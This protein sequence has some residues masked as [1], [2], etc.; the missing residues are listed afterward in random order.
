MSVE[1]MPDIFWIGVNDRTTDLFEGVWPIKEGVSY[2]SYL[3][4]DEKTVLVDLVKGNQLEEFL[5]K[6]E[7][8]IDP[9]ELDYVIINHMEPDHSGILKAIRRCAPNVQIVGTKRMIPMVEAFYGITKDIVEV[10]DGSTLNLGKRTLEFFRTPFV[11]WPETMMTFERSN[12]I[13]FSCDGFG[14]FGALRGAIFDDEVPDLEY[15][16]DEALRYYANIVAKFSQSVLGAI[17]KLSDL[18]IKVIAPSHGVIWRDHPEDIIQLYQKWASYAKGPREKAVTLVYGSMYGN[19]ESVMNFV[20]RGISRE[21]VPVEICDAARIHS[22]YILAYLWKN[23]G[24]LIGA[25]TYEVELFPPVAHVLDMARRKSIFGRKA[26][27]FGSFGWGGGAKREFDKFAEALKW[28]TIG[29]FVFQGGA[30]RQEQQQAEEF[31]QEFAR[32]ILNSK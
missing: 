27:Y 29:E 1:I 9:S 5:G 8:L 22:S 13:L 16:R 23:E 25:P 31:G 26:G 30:T 14:G 19:T 2:N 20:A 21:K 17:K 6:V 3:I 7:E 28:E 18:P 32:K 12:G 11:H 10:G 15:Y 24:V 4:R